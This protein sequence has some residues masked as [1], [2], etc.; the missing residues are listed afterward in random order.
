MQL[1]RLEQNYRS[2]EHLTAA[3]ALIGHNGDRLGKDLWTEGE[4]IPSLFMSTTSWMRPASSPTA[5]ANGCPGSAADEIAILYRSNA[6]SRNLEEAL[7]EARIPIEFM[8]LRFFERRFVTP[9]LPAP[10]VEPG[11]GPGL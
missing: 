3:N 8:R 4:V 6:Q 11:F 1:V 7:P 10:Y 2:T 5:S 9:G